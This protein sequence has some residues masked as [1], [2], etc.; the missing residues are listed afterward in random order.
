[1]EW[2]EKRW[3]NNSPHSGHYGCTSKSAARDPIHPMGGPY[4]HKRLLLQA[5][6][7]HH[8]WI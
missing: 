4:I 5:E 1:V 7:G 3:M 2:Q 6:E 8:G